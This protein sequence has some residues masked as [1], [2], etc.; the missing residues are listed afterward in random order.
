MY[1]DRIEYKNNLL[2]EYLKANGWKMLDANDPQTNLYLKLKIHRKHLEE[3]FE[4]FDRL[5]KTMWGFIPDYLDASYLWFAR[6]NNKPSKEFVSLQQKRI[7]KLEER[8]FEV[9]KECNRFTT[10][11]RLPVICLETG[12]WFE[13]VK[14]VE[15]QLGYFE[16]D[17][18]ESCQ[19]D[20]AVDGFHFTYDNDYNEWDIPDELS[21]EEWIKDRKNLYNQIYNKKYYEREDVKAKAKEVYRQKKEKAPIRKQI[22]RNQRGIKCIETGMIWISLADCARSL[23]TTSAY[24]CKVLNKKNGLYKGNHYEYVDNIGYN[25]RVMCIDTGEIFDTLSDASKKM[26]IS[27]SGIARVCDGIYQQIKG[28]KFKW[29]R[30]DEE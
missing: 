9:D 21:T 19:E 1:F 4:Y 24:L 15:K 25:P 29:V 3:G 30:E 6:F 2:C 11:N 16:E 22:E 17:I 12:Q 28:Y 20:T 14:Q 18:I 7:E 27:S 23:D 26:D 13:S 8:A 10:N 5:D